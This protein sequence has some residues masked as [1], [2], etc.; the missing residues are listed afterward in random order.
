LFWTQGWTQIRSQN[1]LKVETKELVEIYY[2][3]S[4]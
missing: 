4:D 3:I 2:D 1:F